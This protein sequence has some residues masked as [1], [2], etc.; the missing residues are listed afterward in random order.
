LQKR[1]IGQLSGGEL[2]RVLLAMAMVPIPDVLLLD[3]PVSAIDPQG[4]SVFYETVCDLRR[5]Y[6]ISILLV[7]HDLADAATHA[8]RMLFLQRS[9]QALGTPDDVL[10]DA[11][12][13]GKLGLRPF[14]AG[15]LAGLSLFAG[16]EDAHGRNAA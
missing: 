6:D 15:K 12:L 3:E 11:A 5:K 8:D 9:I 2:Q 13:M 14:N 1:K 7:T 16:K 4:L 10:G